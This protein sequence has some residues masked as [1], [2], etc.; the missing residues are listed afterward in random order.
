MCAHMHPMYFVRNLTSPFIYMYE[1]MYACRVSTDIILLELQSKPGLEV[2]AHPV[3]GQHCLGHL[4]G[5]VNTSVFATQSHTQTPI[6]TYLHA[7]MHTH[8]DR[9]T[10]HIHILTHTHTHRALHIIYHN[11]GIGAKRAKLLPR[12]P[13]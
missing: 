3:I 5:S 2:F 1:C 6:H 8:V 10:T 9:T 12:P 7:Y 11:A 13:M 4:H